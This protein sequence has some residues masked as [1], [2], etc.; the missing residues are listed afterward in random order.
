MTLIITEISDLG[1]IMA[2]DTASTVG[3]N[4]SRGTVEDRAFKGLVKVLPVN[5]LRAGISYWGWSTLP[6][7]NPNQGVWTD[8]W[9]INFLT[10]NRNDYST[11][12]EL[13]SLLADELNRVVP[14]LTQEELDIHPLGNGGIHLAGYIEHGDRL[15]PCFWHIHN[16]ISQELPDSGIIPTRVNANNDFPPDRNLN[17]LAHYWRNGDFEPFARFSQRLGDLIIELAREEDLIIPIPNLLSRAEFIRA[18]IRFISELYS[19]GADILQEEGV[20]RRRVRSISDEGTLLLI[21]REGRTSYFT[22]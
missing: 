18:Q 4:T 21:P 17:G 12:S 1:I 3:S 22:R 9:L 5:Q 10:R 6:P 7:G 14:E 11:I 15:E 2:G 8:W 19:V 13:A 16:G 20:L